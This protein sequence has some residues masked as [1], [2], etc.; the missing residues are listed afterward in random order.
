LR[1][2]DNALKLYAR[3]PRRADRVA[4]PVLRRLNARLENALEY[5]II[6]VKDYMDDMSRSQRHMYLLQMEQG[7]SVPIFHYTWSWG[8]SRAGVNPHVIWRVPPL[9][10]KTSA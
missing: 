5:D 2:V 1:T 10:E 7:M 9:S 6:D 4:P 8:G 3:E